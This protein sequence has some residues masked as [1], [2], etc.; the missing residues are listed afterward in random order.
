MLS[1]A[2]DLLTSP[3]IK[4]KL[5]ARERCQSIAAAMRSEE[6]KFLVL[7]SY[8]SHF[9]IR[10]LR[11]VGFLVHLL[12]FLSHRALFQ[13]ALAESTVIKKNVRLTMQ[14]D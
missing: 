8:P 9:L 11:V 14:R 3:E 5:V 12:L 10:S 2:V 13:P 7:T 4:Q 6:S 1:K